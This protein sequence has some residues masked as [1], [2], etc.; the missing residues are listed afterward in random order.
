M[1]NELRLLTSAAELYLAQ[2][3]HPASEELSHL[4]EQVEQLCRERKGREVERRKK[5][6]GEED[7][8]EDTRELWE[9]VESVSVPSDLTELEEKVE[10]AIHRLE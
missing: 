9:V 2:Q 4:K 3:G 1:Y 7:D 8:E 5:M 6:K 10:D